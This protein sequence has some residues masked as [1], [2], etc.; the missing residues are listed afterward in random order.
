M[1]LPLVSPGVAP[2]WA[3]PIRRLLL[4][5]AVEVPV[6]GRRVEVHPGPVPGD[7]DAGAPEDGVDDQPAVVL[8]APVLVEVR[9][10]EAERPAAVVALE[11]PGDDL[12]ASL[13]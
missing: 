7:L 9:P 4:G 8:V 12:L 6:Q 5:L 3:A 1:A 11:G 2:P 10:G 13:V